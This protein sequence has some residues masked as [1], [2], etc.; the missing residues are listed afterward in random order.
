M[1][2][3][4]AIVDPP[5]LTI[6][7]LPFRRLHGSCPLSTCVVTTRTMSGSLGPSSSQGLDQTPFVFSTQSYYSIKDWQSSGRQISSSPPHKRF[8]S[9]CYPSCRPQFQFQNRV[10]L[11][12]SSRPANGCSL[13]QHLPDIIV[14]VAMRM[15]TWQHRTRSKH[16]LF[17]SH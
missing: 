12:N 13:P 6:L 10:H 7:S 2:S 5:N 16:A 11:D 3:S 15:A 8:I 14:T 17:E 4:Q 9:C 1:S